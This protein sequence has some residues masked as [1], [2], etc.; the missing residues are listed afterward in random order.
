VLLS[1]ISVV[2]GVAV[3]AIGFATMRDERD[4]PAMIMFGIGSL[5]SG[6][7]LLGMGAIVK[8]LYLIESHLRLDKRSE[9]VS[10]QL[11]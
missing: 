6:L 4:A 2:V 11:H 10:N 3:S 9:A 5:L 7:L 8:Q 1:R